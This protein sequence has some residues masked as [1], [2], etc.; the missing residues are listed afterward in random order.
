MDTED[1]KSQKILVG[2]RRLI[3]HIGKSLS[4]A[5]VPT[6][7]INT[8]QTPDVYQQTLMNSLLTQ[9]SQLATGQ[10]DVSQNLLNQ[11]PTTDNL[12][13]H[14]QPSWQDPQVHLSTATGKSTSSYLDICD[15]IP[16]AVEEELV[17]GGQGDQQVIVKSGPKKPKLENITLSQWSI[18]NLAILYKLAGEGKLMGENLMDYL[19]YTTKE[20]QLV[21]RFSLISV[22]LYDREYRRL[23]ASMNFRWGTDVQHLHTLHSNKGINH[24]PKLTSLGAQNLRVVPQ[25]KVK[26]G[27]IGVSW[28]FVA[29][30]T[31]QKDA[32]IH[33]VSLKLH[34][35]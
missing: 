14:S 11:P 30:L 18:A 15:F 13:G 34:T 29:I 9:Q 10:S 19:S 7:D 12:P 17:I 24:L 22:L 8:A 16:N 6:P 25:A 3:I 31:H 27:E 2:Q 23:Q 33:S 28:A 21:Q 35:L 26:K 1:L 5:A 4:S 20:Y 32:T